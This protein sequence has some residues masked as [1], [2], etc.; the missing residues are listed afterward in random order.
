MHHSTKTPA[1]IAL[2]FVM[3]FLSLTATANEF[4]KDVM[5]IGGSSKDVDMV[6]NPLKSEGWTFIDYDL[7]NGCGKETDYI[8]LLYKADNNSNSYNNGYISDFYIS[9]AEGIAPDTRTID[10]RIYHIVPYDGSFYFTDEKRKGELNSHAG[11]KTI[12]LYYTKEP[13]ADNRA[14]SSITFNETSSGAVVWNGNGK[15]ADLNAGCG[16]G[17]DYIYMHITTATIQP[18][19]ISVAGLDT[20]EVVGRNIRVQGWAYDPDAPSDPQSIIVDVKRADGSDYKTSVISTNVLRADV[21]DKYS[22]NGKHGFNDT[23]SIPNSGTYTVTIYAQDP[24]GD[25]KTQAGTTQTITISS[26]VTLTAESTEVILL[27]GDT[28][29]GK[30]GDYTRVKIAAGATVTLSGADITAAIRSRV[31]DEIWD[32][33]GCKDYAWSGITCLG[34]ATIILADSTENYIDAGC[35]RYAGIQA[36]PAGTT[37]TIRGDG[38]LK[39][40]GGVDGA[41]IGST[42]TGEL[43]DENGFN[44]EPGTC[45]DIVIEGGQIYANTRLTFNLRTKYYIYENVVQTGHA[46][47]IGSGY[48]GKCGNITINGGNIDARSDVAAVIGCG[49]SA[50]CGDITIAGSGVKIYARNV[51]SSYTVIGPDSQ[52]SSNCGTLTIGG[53]KMDYIPDNDWLYAPIDNN[54]TYSVIF[55]AND[56]TDKTIEQVIPYNLTQAF[57]SCTFTRPYHIFECWS[58][59]V[60]GSGTNYADGQEI[61]N[62]TTPNRQVTLY[63]QWLPIYTVHFDKNS[64]EAMGTMEDQDFVCNRMQALTANAFTRTE[65]ALNG[66]NT[67]AD[68]SGNSYSDRQEVENLT[69]EAQTITLYAQWMSIYYT[70]N[71]DKNSEEATGTMEDQIFVLD[72]KQALTANAFTRTDYVFNGWNTDANGSGKSYTD[73]QEIENLI[74]GGQSITLYAQWIIILELNANK[75][76]DLTWYNGK[77]NC[78]TTLQNCT[79]LTD[80]SLNTICLPFSLNSLYGTPFEGFFIMELDTE[81]EYNGHKTGL[82]NGTLYLNFKNATRI[83]AGK[84]YIIK[85]P[86]A[87]HED[88]ILT[89]TTSDSDKAA[90]I[91]GDINTYWEY[92]PDN[93]THSNRYQWFHFQTSM[94]ISV[95]G[96]TLTMTGDSNYKFGQLC[97]YAVENGSSILLH[98]I[99]NKDFVSQ[100]FNIPSSNPYRQF[101]VRVAPRH[102]D[103]IIYLLPFRIAELKLHGICYDHEFVVNPTFK[104]MTINST[105]LTTVTSDDGKVKFVGSYNPLVVDNSNIKEIL[106]MDSETIDYAAAPMTIQAFRAHFEVPANEG[107]GNAPV[108]QIVFNDGETT[109]TITVKNFET[110]HHEIKATNEDGSWYTIYGTKLESEPTEKGMYINNGETYLIK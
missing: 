64:D 63:A 106:N 49:R 27:D 3:L 36:G 57:D 69:T 70:I 65:Y 43:L 93:H 95:T 11:G 47:T 98:T 2:L 20:I 7:N 17:T 22:I 48:E 90:M 33:M 51:N 96:Y 24:T 37:L 104:D 86:G 56:G 67:A 101:E 97:L 58:T 87:I 76:N 39:V 84:P 107:Q 8:Y 23:I 25:G 10:G 13:F 32:F 68:G 41:A 6:L 85:H 16:E 108:S 9:D 46:A 79:F 110:G 73:Q 34:D 61:E 54:C 19:N 94:P 55:K 52:T 74:K 4:I 14:V 53:V 40:R 100:T 82:D 45:G 42:G 1:R 18:R 99:S 109:S 62:L 88:I 66:W 21:N 80:G 102:D 15:P 103:E 89:Y 81:T 26:L 91:D 59:A 38:Y 72:N 35:Y 92:I 30:G 77:K 29:T 12:H 71:F 5:V 105:N 28:L 50:H 44:L 75:D 83:E 31:F 78:K 60:D